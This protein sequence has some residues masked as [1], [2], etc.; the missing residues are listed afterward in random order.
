MYSVHV[1]TTHVYTISMKHLPLSFP[2]FKCFSFWSD[3][4]LKLEIL[5]L[6]I[7][8]FKCISSYRAPRLEVDSMSLT[9]RLHEIFARAP[10]NDT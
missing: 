7:Y 9:T 10:Y 8:I 5:F 3:V 6:H 4:Q 2:L 1:L